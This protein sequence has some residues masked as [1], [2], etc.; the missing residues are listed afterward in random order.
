M[1]R[2][3]LLASLIGSVVLADEFVAPAPGVEEIDRYVLAR[4]PP[5]VVKLD[6]MTGAS[7]YL[8]APAKSKGR[9]G[10][11]RLREIPGLTSGPAGRYRLSE[12][13]PLILFDTVSGRAWARCEAPTTDK[14]EGWCQIDE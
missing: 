9:Q 13:T 12:G 11:C 10:W 1:R 6:S 2:L 14:G 7:W 5:L 3:P 8:C 4:T